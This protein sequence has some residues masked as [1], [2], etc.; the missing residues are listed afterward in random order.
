MQNVLWQRRQFDWH[1]SKKPSYLLVLGSPE[2]V[3]TEIEYTY[4][5]IFFRRGSSSYIMGLLLWRRVISA[6]VITGPFWFKHVWFDAAYR[7][8]ISLLHHLTQ[9]FR[10]QSYFQWNIRRQKTWHSST[11]QYKYKAKSKIFIIFGRYD[12]LL[13]HVSL[14]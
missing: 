3:C 11:S 13:I 7:K 8:T 4:H 6:L 5:S 14:T 12:G 1:G 2:L 10:F 9:N